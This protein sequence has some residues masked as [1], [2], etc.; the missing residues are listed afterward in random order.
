MH[1]CCRVDPLQN[2]AEQWAEQAQVRRLGT[3]K[4]ATEGC[5]RGY[6]GHGSAGAQQA[7]ALR[8]RV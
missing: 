7:Q 3:Y 1:I 6:S 4:E 8:P 2:G 5:K